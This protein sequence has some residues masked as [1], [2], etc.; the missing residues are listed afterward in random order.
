[1]EIS[2]RPFKTAWI[3]FLHFAN[4]KVNIAFALAPN[5]DSQSGNAFYSTNHCYEKSIVCSVRL[6][7]W[8]VK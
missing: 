6:D 3:I 5:I 4:V 1:M 8:S 7:N 2:R